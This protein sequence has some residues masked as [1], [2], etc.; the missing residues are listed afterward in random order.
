MSLN[1]SPRQQRALESLTAALQRHFFVRLHGQPSR[2][3]STI[4]RTLHGQTGGIFLSA[5]D[6]VE[7]G[8]T[9]DPIAIEESFFTFLSAKLIERAQEYIY[10]DDFSAILRPAAGPGNP[11]Q[12][13]MELAIKAVLDS[14]I[15]RGKKLIFEENSIESEELGR[16][17]LSIEVQALAT[18]DYS[19]LGTRWMGA[20]AAKSI[21]FGQIYRFAPRL[22][23]HQFYRAC[24][25]VFGRKDIGTT[26]LIE[27]LRAE[28]LPSNVDLERVAAVDLRL[29]EG[30]EE[31]VRGLAAQVVL[32]LENDQAVK[33]FAL[34]PKRGVLIAGPPG[35]GKTTIGR[36]LAHRLKGKFLSIDATVLSPLGDCRAAMDA[37]IR[38]AFASS[39]AVLF[40]DDADALFADA[41]PGACRYL[42]A[43][44][45]GL[46]NEVGNGIALVVTAR[47]ANRLPAA[48]IE[49]GRIESW[50]ETRLPNPASRGRIFQEQLA[51]LGESLRRVEPQPVLAASEGF[52]GADIKSAVEEAKALFAYD[53]LQNQPPRTPT[54]YLLDGVARVAMC[55]QRASAT[56]AEAASDIL[57]A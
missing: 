50:L 45:D 23:L 41:P 27:Q 12:G 51:S 48:L 28:C 29:L 55:R 33:E 43:R 37:V 47:N 20:D 6:Y 44:L 34:R 19:F 53:R 26:G 21:D 31:V 54:E 3:K 46:E 5:R 7:A 32:P 52:S 16:R 56:T 14:A 57:K 35:T 22:D 40:I 36:A 1:L 25:Q 15:T 39:P 18:E 9:R 2:G 13:Y 8:L 38:R 49:S 30:V 4:L 24:L 17:S 10:L 42:L 11:R